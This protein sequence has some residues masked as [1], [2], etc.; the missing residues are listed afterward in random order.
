M[1][2]L[3]ARSPPSLS[4]ISNVK[5][6]DNQIPMNDYP[7]GNRYINKVTNVRVTINNNINK[8]EY[9]PKSITVQKTVTC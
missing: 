1:R 2:E 5:D 4:L 9:S 3:E 6:V 8:F 7:H